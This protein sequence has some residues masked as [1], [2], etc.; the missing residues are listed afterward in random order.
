MLISDLL[1]TLKI[2]FLFFIFYLL[3]AE[4]IGE[5]VHLFHVG[6]SPNPVFLWPDI[7]E[8]SDRPIANHTYL[9]YPC[10]MSWWLHYTTELGPI[11][12]RQD[13]Q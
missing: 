12:L 10:D 8:S 4:S 3:F 11:R 5:G 7:E 6:E 2:I 1:K 9:P 13:P